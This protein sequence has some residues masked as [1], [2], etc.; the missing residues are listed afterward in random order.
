MGNR[1]QGICMA[2]GG[3]TQESPEQLMARMAAKY[4]APTGATQ[5]P[6]PQSTQQP[7]QQAPQQPPQKSNPLGIMSVL[8]GRSAQIDKAVNGYADGGIAGHVKFEG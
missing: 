6:Q 8:K 5:Q 7:P 2:D 1:K 4:G 3:I